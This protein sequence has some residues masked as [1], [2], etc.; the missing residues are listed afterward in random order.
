MYPERDRHKKASTADAHIGA[1]KVQAMLSDLNRS[2]S[3][4]LEG[5]DTEALETAVEMINSA[6]RVFV[7]GVGHSGAI[8]R[9]L[10]MKLAHV[11]VSAVPVFSEI[12]PPFDA[13]SVLIAISQ[14]GETTTVVTLAEKARRLGGR[15]LG[16]TGN[17]ESTLAR[18][19]ACVLSLAPI[20]HEH[21]VQ[22][23]SVLGTRDQQNVRGTVFGFA[24]FA[25]SYSLVV[26]LAQRRK[27]SPASIDARHANLE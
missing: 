15:V 17:R 13:E 24:L 5:I 22:S 12:I 4:V 6:P 7:L 20:P 18:L 3:A 2:A 23:L 26:T 16:I 10:T 19:S 14:S 9:I 27:E 21:E 11:G 1:A 8:A 25:L